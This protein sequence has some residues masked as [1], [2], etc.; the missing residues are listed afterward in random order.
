ME[1]PQSDTLQS[2]VRT[3]FSAGRRPSLLIVVLALWLVSAAVRFAMYDTRENVVDLDATY[4]VLLTVQAYRETPISVHR[5]WPLVTLGNAPE[6]G[7][8]FGT[9]VPDAR[10]IYYYTS[11]APAGFIAPYLFFQITRLPLTPVSLMLFN[12]GIHLAATILLCLLLRDVLRALGRSDEDSY[13]PIIF[14]AAT[15]L[16]STESLFSHGLIYWHHSLFQVVW[17]GQLRL[18]FMLLRAR[19]TNTPLPRW[20]TPAFLGLALLAPSVEWAGYI[21]NVAIAGWLLW[22]ARAMAAGVLAATFVA[23]IA[24]LAH[25]TS[26]V[27]L[28]PLM[29][30]LEHSFHYRGRAYGSLARL[31]L[32]YVQ[33]Y[34]LL[35]LF[36]LATPLVVRARRPGGLGLTR[37]VVALLVVG[38]IP[39]VE[40]LL[41]LQHATE[42]NFDRL[43]ALIP[44][45]LLGAIAL[46]LAG[47]VTRRVLA[48]VWIALLV[49][50]V[51]NRPGRIRDLTVAQAHNAAVL[52][53][54]EKVTKPCTLYAVNSFARGW[55]YLTL[56]HNVAEKVVSPDSLRAVTLR[57]NACQGVL[58]VGD[59]NGNQIYDWTG[60]L[61]FD[62]PDHV[63]ALVLPRPAR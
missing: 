51:A 33:S 58:L 32:G 23:G 1:I 41:L 13:V 61:V 15:Y 54:L 7:I 44:I 45:C 29:G 28:A 30:S 20:F 6:R 43:K 22:S 9:T 50:N 10:G 17:L 56:N 27:G 14:A 37:P 12:L 21:A 2:K 5:F 63:R 35:P 34:F 3:P 39:L 16:F 46:S 24:F 36:A 40:N 55:V 25:V 62:P 38:T 53:A 49:V 31:A 4:H 60:A 18:F 19:E 48:V 57:H 11:F 59:E 8:P 47:T 42:Y 52:G 26:V